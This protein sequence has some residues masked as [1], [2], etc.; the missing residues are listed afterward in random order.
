MK[1]A[2]L[3]FV[4]LVFAGGLSAQS[5]ARFGQAEDLRVFPNPVTESF[6]VGHTDRV[7]TLN[8]MNMAGRV[9]KKFTYAPDGKYNVTDLHKG[10]YLLQ[11]RDE[12][13]LVVKTLRL[14][15]R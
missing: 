4:F 8:L 13:N 15:K 1:H 7:K 14:N 5:S 12:R 10:I 3:L 11:L 2:L 6:K 9:V